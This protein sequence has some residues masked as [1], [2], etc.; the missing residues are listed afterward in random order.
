MIDLEKIAKLYNSILMSISPI[1]NTILRDHFTTMDEVLKPSLT[2]LNWSS[3]GVSAFITKA[4]IAI[5]T[6]EAFL[7]ESRK[8]SRGEHLPVLFYSF[9]IFIHP[10]F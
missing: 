9:C 4:N 2:Y 5:D 10:T 8:H 7:E 1:E 6:F 3:Q